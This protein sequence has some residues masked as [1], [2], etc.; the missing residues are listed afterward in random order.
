M[1]TPKDARPRGRRK[2]S[3]RHY[4]IPF[5]GGGKSKQFPRL[6]SLPLALIGLIR[7]VDRLACILSN[8]S[9]T[10]DVKMVALGSPK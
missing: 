2:G 4:S 1:S 10:S 3:A 7:K 5:K 6:V 8:L 9:R